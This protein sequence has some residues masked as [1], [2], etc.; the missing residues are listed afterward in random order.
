M[1]YVNEVPIY[2]LSDI[3]DA[4]KYQHEVHG[5]RYVVTD[6]MQ[7][8][9]VAG[10]KDRVEAITIVSHTVR[11]TARDC[12]VTSIALSQF[13]RETSKDYENPPTP[14][15]LMG[16]SPLE[17]DSDQ[18]VLLNHAKYDRDPMTDSATTQ[19]L[20]AKNRHGPLKQIDV[21]W[22]YSTLRITEQTH[23]TIPLPEGRGEA[24]EPGEAA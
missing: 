13:N 1:M 24:W 14:Q 2:Q 8:A 15:G 6:Y 4:I 5:C 23:V 18:V 17:N 16:G 11:N 19:V 7:L 21:T 22:Q 20:L 9:E 3:A 10:V 12:G